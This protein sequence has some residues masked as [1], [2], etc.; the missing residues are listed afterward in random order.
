M[1][2]KI[3]N[4]DALHRA[5]TKDLRRIPGVGPAV[6]QDLLDLGVRRVD[7]LRGRDP[8]QLYDEL[9]VF[10][11]CRVDRC[12]LYVFRLAVYYAETPHPDPARCKWWLWKD[13]A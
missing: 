3:D 8:Q 9:C 6:A 12:M 2:R 11:G 4:T 5:A 7:D 13:E 1:A 10:Q